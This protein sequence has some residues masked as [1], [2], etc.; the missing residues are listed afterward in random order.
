MTL[1]PRL[2]DAFRHLDDPAALRELAELTGRVGLTRLSDAWR[3]E[4][5]AAADAP[6]VTGRLIDRRCERS[7]P[8]NVLPFRNEI[9]GK[10]SLDPGLRGLHACLPWDRIHRRRAFR[11]GYCWSILRDGGGSRLRDPLTGAG[12]EVREAGD[13]AAAEQALSTFRPDVILVQ[14]RPGAES[15][16]ELLGRLKANPEARSIPV[17]LYGSAA[18]AEERI[19]VRAGRRRSALAAA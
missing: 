7:S 9:R 10:F 2:A 8:L 18:T 17:I 3:A 4:A 16:L 11:A 6:Q 14:L 13:L 5:R 12:L 19:R 1:G 15:G